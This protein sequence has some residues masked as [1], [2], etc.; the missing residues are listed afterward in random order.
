[1]IRPPED[2]IIPRER[3]LELFK[4]LHGESRRIV[5]TNG[6]FDLFHLGHKHSL[7]EAKKKGDILIVGLDSDESV[8]KLKGPTRPI[9]SET[10]RAELLSAMEAVD[11]VTIFPSGG[12]IKY[13]DI[14]K[15]NV[16]V[17]SGN[18]NLETIN[19]S[20]RKLVES[21]GG[22]IF[23]PKGISGFSTTEVIKKIKNE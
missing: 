11:F 19:Q 1:M 22:E 3:L 7:E 8:K 13:I 14:L 10:E 15:P 6:C 9:Y 4:R 12:A 18:Y 2:K 17:K 21:Y 16:Y 23:L 5:T 20:E